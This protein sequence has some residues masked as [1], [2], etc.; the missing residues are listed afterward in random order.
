[1]VYGDGDGAIFKKFTELSVIG[2][3]MTH[4]IVQF[5]GGLIYQ[6]QSGALNE[7][8]ADVFGSLTIQKKLSQSACQANWLVGEGILGPIINGLALRSMKAPGTAYNDTVLGQDPQPYHMDYYVDTTSDNGGVHINSGIPNQAFYLYSQYMGGNAW[9]K[10]GQIWYHALQSLNN[11]NATF[12]QWAEK[13]MEAAMEIHGIGTWET[14][15]L[16]RA[17]KL[18]GIDV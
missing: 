10:P 2:H 6:G 1:M 15:M 7:S 16:K 9:D 3:E 14:G 8:I 17:W 18:V 5:S 11:P 13:T 12:Q 4:G